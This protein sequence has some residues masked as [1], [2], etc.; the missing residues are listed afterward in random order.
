MTTD[1]REDHWRQVYRGK[2]S[3]ELT[4]YQE[5]PA[6]SIELIERARRSGD[7]DPPIRLIDVGAGASTLEDYLV[8]DE[9]F[10]LTA[11]DITDAALQR[12]RQRIGSKADRIDWVEADVTDDLDDLEPFDIWHDRAVF[13]FLTEAKDRRAYLQNL[14]RLVPEGYAVI[15]TFSLE[16]PETCSGLPVRRYSADSL[17]EALGEAWRLLTSR[18]EDHPT[19]WGGTQN[20]VYGLF[21]RS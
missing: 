4:W 12:T 13:H 6:V 19:P 8:S 1:S 11:L 16:G 18:R 17:A 5:R 14:G 2:D 15:S 7:L 9:S 21:A 10:A 3:E 20:F